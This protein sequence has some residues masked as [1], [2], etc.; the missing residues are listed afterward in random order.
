VRNDQ[1]NIIPVV[2]DGDVSTP[3]RTSIQQSHGNIII[4]NPDMMHHT[5]LPD[6]RSIIS[7][8]TVILIGSFFALYCFQFEA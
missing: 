6:V 5:L 1:T 7:F 2:C 3:E 4:T 8:N